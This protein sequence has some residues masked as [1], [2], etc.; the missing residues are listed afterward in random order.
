LHVAMLPIMFSILVVMIGRA[1]SIYPLLG[2]LNLTKKEEPIPLSWMHLLS[3]GSLRGSLAIVMVLLI[4]DNVELTGWNY[5][6]SVK[7]FVT[8]I[9]IGSIYFTLLVKATTIGKVMN[10]LGIDALSDYEEVSY[11]KSKVLI[12]DEALKTLDQLLKDLKISEAQ[13]RAMRESYRKLH[14]KVS[15]EYKEKFGSS[16]AYIEHLLRIFVL[17]MEKEEL[18]EIYRRGEINEKIYKKILHMLDIQMERVE[19]GHSQLNAL[20]EKF[21]ADGFERFINGVRRLFFIKPGN[22]HPQDLYIYYRTQHKMLETVIARLEGL[23]DTSL[24]E[25][26]DDQRALDKIIAL[27]KQLLENT[28]CKLDDMLKTNYEFLNEFNAI[29][30]QKALDSQQLETLDQLSKNEIITRKLYIM[31]HNELKED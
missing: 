2:F 19:K 17:G 6:F 22:L 25:V 20:D 29:T 26:F 10:K 31:L 18:K 28:K 3:W 23:G 5:S 11:Y 27:Y 8:A 24:I 4:P 14:H 13:Y 9:T 7:D 30:G 15:A 1:L 16:T 21:P 12:Y